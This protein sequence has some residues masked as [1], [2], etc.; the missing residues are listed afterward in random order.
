MRPSQDLLQ[1]RINTYLKG[2]WYARWITIAIVAASFWFIP[3][4]QRDVIEIL[5]GVA[6]IYNILVFI[7]GQLGVGFLANRVFI[8]LVDGAMAL[9]LVAYSGF[10]ESPYLFILLFMIVSAAFWYGLRGVVLT[11]VLQVGSFALLE[12][13]QHMTPVPKLLIIQTLILITIGL[14]VSWLT[15]N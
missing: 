14:Y 2:T 12:H 9:A 6:V 10:A 1:L 3:E 4:A 5:F 13:T 11:A 7:G 8:I 15:K